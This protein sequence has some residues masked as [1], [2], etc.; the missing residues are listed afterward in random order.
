LLNLFFIFTIQADFPCKLDQTRPL[1]ETIASSTN[2]FVREV[3]SSQK[4]VETS[5]RLNGSTMF[6]KE[7][8][9]T[10]YCRPQVI[11]KIREVVVNH[12]NPFEGNK[13]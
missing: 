7:T 3:V 4:E 9:G 8:F 1:Q 2:A 13:T 6:F 12:A 11:E 5:R 10:V